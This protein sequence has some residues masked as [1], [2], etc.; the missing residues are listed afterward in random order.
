M[1]QVLRLIR[2]NPAMTVLQ[3]AR[4]AALACIVFTVPGWDR[5]P[6]LAALLTVD[7]LVV[8]TVRSLRP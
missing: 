2:R 6:A 3:A 4:T 8:R 1:T 7:Y 5:L